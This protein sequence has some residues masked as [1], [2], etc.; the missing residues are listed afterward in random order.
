MG[1]AISFASDI[2]SI[3]TEISD[4]FAGFTQPFTDPSVIT[5]NP[6]VFAVMGKILASICCSVHAIMFNICACYK[7]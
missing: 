6:V 2:E 4:N 7:S 5:H 1:S 3:G